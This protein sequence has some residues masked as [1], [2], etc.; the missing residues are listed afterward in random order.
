M[1]ISTQ[2]TSTEDH[3]MRGE[4]RKQ[5]TMFSYISPEQ[6]VTQDHPLRAIR[7][8]TDEALRSLS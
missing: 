1:I 4:D 3:G 5:A 6:R 2:S 7:E 8:M